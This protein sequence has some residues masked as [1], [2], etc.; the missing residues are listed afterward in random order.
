MNNDYIFHNV[1]RELTLNSVAGKAVPMRKASDLG[2]KYGEG[3]SYFTNAQKAIYS[4]DFVAHWDVTDNIKVDFRHLGGKNRQIYTVDAPYSTLYRY[5]TPEGVSASPE[6]TPTLIIRQNGINGKT[7]P[8]VGVYE[9]HSGEAAVKSLNKQI[10]KSGEL[11]FTVELV[12]GRTDTFTF[13]E[14]DGLA[15]VRK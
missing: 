12:D 4:S 11:I 2:T 8:F 13:T 10:S 14:K 9:A 7:Q 6:P 5:L 15:V 1:G 3:Y